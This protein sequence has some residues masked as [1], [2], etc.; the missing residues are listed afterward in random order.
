[1]NAS[2]DSLPKTW[3]FTVSIIW[4]PMAA[5]HRKGEL[6]TL[7]MLYGRFWTGKWQPRSL[8]D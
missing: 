7:K 1:M 3:Y 2:R 4:S 8:V 5:T 6:L